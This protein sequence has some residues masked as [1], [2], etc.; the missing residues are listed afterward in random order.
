M[1][2]LLARKPGETRVRKDGYIALGEEAYKATGLEVANDINR[3]RGKN[4]VLYL[5]IRD[6]GKKFGQSLEDAFGALKIPYLRQPA[7]VS[8]RLRVVFSP[9]QLQLAENIHRLKSDRPEYGIT[10]VVYDDTVDKGT[11]LLT[12]YGFLKD[13]QSYPE[14]HLDDIR[15]AACMD[16]SGFT[17]YHS[18][19]WTDERLGKDKALDDLRAEPTVDRLTEVLYS[20]LPTRMKDPRDVI[21]RV[22]ML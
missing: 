14:F 22:M 3:D 1:N 7:F 4:S 19:L 17:D 16:S 20:F 13:L 9:T 8:K 5:P 10:A 11:R 18:L 21:G 15:L 12:M 2:V 6:G